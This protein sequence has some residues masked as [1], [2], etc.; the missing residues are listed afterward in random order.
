MNKISET[1]KSKDNNCGS[2]NAGNN[3]NKKSIQKEKEQQS[4]N[5]YSVN[6]NSS[7]KCTYCRQDGHFTI[8]CFKYP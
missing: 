1:K 6:K 4:N 8:K 2:S 5:N 7:M 3:K